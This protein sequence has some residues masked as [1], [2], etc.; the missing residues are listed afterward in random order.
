M[1]GY[2]LEKWGSTLNTCVHAHGNNVKHFMEASL[3]IIIP[4][5][6]K[7]NV[8][9]LGFR[10]IRLLVYYVQNKNRNFGCS[11]WFYV[12][13]WRVKWVW[14]FLHITFVQNFQLSNLFHNFWSYRSLL[15]L[16]IST[17][18]PVLDRFCFSC[19]VCLFWWIY[20]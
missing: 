5:Y 18:Y 17:D 10:M 14:N 6:Y 11:M 4:L 3:K 16:Q 1:E 9:S 13:Y 20:G 2:A 7:N 19:V 12:F 15:N 8:P